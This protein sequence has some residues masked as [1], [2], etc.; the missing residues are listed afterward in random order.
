MMTTDELH[1]KIMNLACGI[2]LLLIAI[3][4]LGTILLITE[5]ARIETK[6]N[7]LQQQCAPR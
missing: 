5:H 2:T 3:I 4:I 6:V 1:G 7:Q